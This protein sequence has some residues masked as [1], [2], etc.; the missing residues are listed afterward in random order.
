M[1]IILL[2]MSII[3]FISC[4]TTQRKKSNWTE[5]EKELIFKD[6]INY[7]LDIKGL[8]LNESN[9]YCNCTLRILVTKFD[10]KKEAEESLIKNI[11]SNSIYEPCEKY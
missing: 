11:T 7:T 4:N 8:N 10:S 2:M 3:I 9:K 1:R 6:C 5:K